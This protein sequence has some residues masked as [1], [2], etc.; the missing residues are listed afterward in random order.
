MVIS[1]GRF[2]IIAS[3]GWHRVIPWEDAATNK[4]ITPLSEYFAGYSAG[5]YK[6]KHAAIA[7]IWMSP[8]E[9]TLGYEYGF[10]TDG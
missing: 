4:D 9:I 1:I 3:I 5:F 2:E 6:S 7:R 8:F 10:S